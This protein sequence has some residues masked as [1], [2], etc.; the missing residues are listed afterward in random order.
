[1]QVAMSGLLRTLVDT[2]RASAL[3]LG[4]DVFNKV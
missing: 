1:L 3:G 2:A 4:E